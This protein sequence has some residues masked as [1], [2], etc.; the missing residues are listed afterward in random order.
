MALVYN[1][2]PRSRNRLICNTNGIISVA[3]ELGAFFVGG[4][5][6]FLCSGAQHQNQIRLLRFK[7]KV[8]FVRHR[9]VFEP[10]KGD[11]SNNMFRRGVES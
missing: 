10:T 5:L 2:S 1:M 6:L 11:E 9:G 8:T 3:I 7:A 4:A